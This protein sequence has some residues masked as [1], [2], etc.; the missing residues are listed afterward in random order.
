MEYERPQPQG[1]PP[2]NYLIFA[3]LMTI[4]CCWPVGIF[5]IIKATKVKELW[6]LGDYAGAQ[7]ASDD[8]K[9]LTIWGAVGALVLI[10]VPIIILF[11]MGAFATLMDG[12]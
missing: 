3:I 1:A 6:A 8:A 5:A 2:E 11:S 7:K 4:F 12:H 10:V 9:K